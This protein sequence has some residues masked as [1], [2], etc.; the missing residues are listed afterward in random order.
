MEKSELI[1]RLKTHCSMFDP[2]RM[3][4]RRKIIGE[5]F[6]Q[7]LERYEIPDDVCIGE[8]T[9]W[10]K[11]CWWL[12]EGWEYLRTSTDA[13]PQQFYVRMIDLCTD[14][15][16]PALINVS[17]G[18]GDR[19]SLVRDVGYIIA[20]AIKAE[21]FRKEWKMRCEAE[22][23]VVLQAIDLFLRKVYRPGLFDLLEAK[24]PRGGEWNFGSTTLQIGILSGRIT[25]SFERPD[26][27][28]E[29]GGKEGV[30]FIGSAHKLYARFGIH[31]F[32]TTLPRALDMIN[33]VVDS[34]P[35]EVKLLM[36]LLG[37]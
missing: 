5:Y 35:T 34:C 21:D 28:S 26:P 37:I 32:H 14:D 3:T 7:F 30:V 13:L 11:L 15:V 6:G 2:V 27:F 20:D 8:G 25:I 33:E 36:K 29:N 19:S 12:N 17:C 23:E 16:L 4:P 10:E 31:A 22:D 24:K 18:Y 1:K 9:K